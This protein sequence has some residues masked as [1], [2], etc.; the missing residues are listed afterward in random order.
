MTDPEIQELVDLYGPNDV[1][2][3]ELKAYLQPTGPLGPFVRHPLVFGPA[4]I[5]GY[6]NRQLKMKKE[7][8]ARAEREG[9]W[10]H[11]LM[12]H[13][14][15]WRIPVL[16]RLVFENRLTRGQLQDLLL[17]TWMDTEFPHQFRKTPLELFTHAGFVTDNQ[18]AWNALSAPLILYRGDSRR[19][20]ATSLSWTLSEEKAKWFARRWTPGVVWRAHLMDKSKALAFVTGRNELEVVV[21]PK[22][23]KWLMQLA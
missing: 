20:R 11:Y 18:V 6:L 21:S 9:N 22:N 10:S 4:D 13:E 19:P 8:L 17:S 16:S 14:R 2:D 3:E 23:L 1:L 7:H 12:L 5:P 15:P